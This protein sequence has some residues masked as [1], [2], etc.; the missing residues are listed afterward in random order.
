MPFIE[1]A[2]NKVSRKL[3]EQGLRG[4]LS[5]DKI[6]I[7]I[8]EK[9]EQSGGHGDKGTGFR[10]RRLRCRGMTWATT[11]E[12]KRKRL[13]SGKHGKGYQNENLHHV[14]KIK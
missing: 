10:E 11:A 7:S 14:S 5:N 12:M 1:Q 9:A 4:K 13:G 2:L 6:K 8:F 3:C